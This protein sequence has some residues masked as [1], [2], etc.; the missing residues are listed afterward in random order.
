LW[1]LKVERVEGGVPIPRVKNIEELNVKF[2]E[3]CHRY[4]S[5][6]ISG[7]EE[8]VGIMHTKGTVLFVSIFMTNGG[9][10]C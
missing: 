9:L 4:L 2:R 10:I 7:K 8:T 1:F 6:Q 5:H 3:K